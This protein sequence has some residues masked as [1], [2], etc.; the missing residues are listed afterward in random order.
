VDRSLQETEEGAYVSPSRATSKKRTLRLRLFV[1]GEAPNSISAVRNLR[2]TLAA[3]PSVD[4][5]LE[6]VDVLKHPELAL[7]ENVLVTPTM[8]K[9]S[10][11]PVR[12]IIGNLKD[13]AALLAVL[14]LVNADRE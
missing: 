11:P 13:T 5:D 9:L 10:P 12:R 8:I 14:G 7:R 4:A 2:A 1:A 6:V 3:Y